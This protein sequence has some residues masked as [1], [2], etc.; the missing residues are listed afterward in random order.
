MMCYLVFSPQKTFTLLDFK[1]F[2]FQSTWW[3]ISQKRA[4][5]TTLYIY[6]RIMC[7][8]HSLVYYLQWL[9]TEKLVYYDEYIIIV[10]TIRSLHAIFSTTETQFAYRTK[11][12]MYTSIVFFFR[13]YL[14]GLVASFGEMQKKTGLSERLR[15]T[16]FL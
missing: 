15:K 9:A 8:Q 1:Y 14:W 5:C 16:V 2:V 10:E 6:V 4:V 11:K 7:V 12:N 13:I 3:R